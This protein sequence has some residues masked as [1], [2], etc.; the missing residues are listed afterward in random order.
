MIVQALARAVLRRTD[1]SWFAIRRYRAH[2]LEHA[3]HSVI[4]SRGNPQ[5][6]SGIL[7]AQ[8]APALNRLLPADSF[9][10]SGSHQSASTSAVGSFG[11][12]SPPK[13]VYPG[14]TS[15]SSRSRPVGAN[16]AFFERFLAVPAREKSACY[17]ASACDAH[18][19]Y[20]SSFRIA[21]VEAKSSDKFGIASSD[22]AA[23]QLY[24]R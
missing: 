2:C 16:V 15:R 7:G 1:R 6:A 23:R 11:R 10:P 18:L 20:N 12:L 9:S 22:F 4:R 8:K 21:R 3:A 5:S 24:F 13:T 19:K 17:F 14:R